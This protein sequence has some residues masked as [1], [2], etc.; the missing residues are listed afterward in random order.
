[1]FRED[2]GKPVASTT[3]QA[4]VIEGMTV[5]KSAT[6]NLSRTPPGNYL[7]GIRLQGTEWSYYRAVVQ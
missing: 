2:L 1:M 7:F 5:V 4:T 6:L 3:G